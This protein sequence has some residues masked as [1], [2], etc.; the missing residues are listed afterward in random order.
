MERITDAVSLH[1]EG[2]FWDAVGR[3]LLHVDMLA[4]DVIEVDLSG[5]TAR[6]HVG[7][8]A[9]VIRARTSGG[10]LIALERGFQ[11]F[12]DRFTCLG[13]LLPAF[14]NPRIRMNEGGCD[15]QGRFYCGTMA[16]D[17]SP[18]AGAV[19]RLDP[20]RSIHTVLENVTISNGL[21]WHADGERVYY[22]DTPT[23][24]VDVFDFDGTT[25]TFTN[26]RKFVGFEDGVGAPDGMGIDAEGGIWLAMFG[27][28]SVRRYDS[29]GHLSEVVEVPVRNATACTFGGADRR[30]L[31]ITTS[32]LGLGGEAEPGAG[33]VFA[34]EAGVRGAEQ[35]AYAG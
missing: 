33:A 14:E 10:F 5:A 25:G 11:C 32:R 1:G 12:D 4:G 22:T 29:E 17:M 23:R 30:T 8:V 21:Q 7:S 16:Y 20:D 2:P 15:P 6:H 28:S 31:F 3:R 24:R 34:Y 27:G 9:A 13:A 26:R 18:G 35:Y 19:W